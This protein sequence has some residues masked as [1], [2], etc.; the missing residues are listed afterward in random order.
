MMRVNQSV[1][2][3]F[4]AGQKHMRKQAQA[5]LNDPRGSARPAFHLYQLHF[6]IQLYTTYIGIEYFQYK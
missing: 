3:T 6:H 4:G 1:E 2:M 5:A